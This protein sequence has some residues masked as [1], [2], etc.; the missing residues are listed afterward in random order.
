MQ[1][2]E[3]PLG[4]CDR[5]GP[6]LRLGNVLRDIERGF[7]QFS[8]ESL[9]FYMKSISDYDPRP[10]SHQQTR[11]SRTHPASSAGHQNNLVLQTSH[12]PCLVPLVNGG[13]A[14][15]RR[16]RGRGDHAGPYTKGETGRWMSS[17]PKTA[18]CAARTEIFDG[19]DNVVGNL[20]ELADEGEVAR[21]LRDDL[22]PV[23][24]HARHEL[25][26]NVRHH[27]RYDARSVEDV[28]NTLC[29]SQVRKQFDEN[30]TP[31]ALR[32]GLMHEVTRLIRE[33][34]IAPP[35]QDIL[36]L[37]VKVRLTI[38]DDGQEPI[39]VFDRYQSAL[40]GSAAGKGFEP[41]E[42]ARIVRRDCEGF[43]FGL[44]D[45]GN[46]DGGAPEVWT[47]DSQTFPKFPRTS[48]SRRIQRRNRVHRT[49]AGIGC[50]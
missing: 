47:L 38:K 19:K 13:A 34:P 33:E 25:G 15:S 21:S 10:L 30:F 17:K 35:H 5:L 24:P 14:S 18:V 11:V 42:E 6:L 48:I 37:F 39:G 2:A 20:A 22:R 4:A 36:R 8:G 46:E 49:V 31:C 40:A 7:A 9:S 26:G 32:H 43:P 12:D 28:R 45:P 50:H 3:A 44:V 1:R 27:R 29:E 41:V 23:G 16:R